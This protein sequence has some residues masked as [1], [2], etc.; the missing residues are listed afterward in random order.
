MKSMADK[1]TYLDLRDRRESF[2][3]LGRETFDVLI[4]GAGITG[5]G[6]A[7]DAARRGLRVAL[8]DA[9]D[10]GAGTSSRSSKLIHGGLRYL[11]QKDVLVVRE[12]AVERR[13]V[14]AIAPHLA[15]LIPI[16]I[17]FE[18]RGL[19]AQLRAALWSYE[20]LGR[21]AQEER[22]EV[23]DVER[24]KA[25]E[26]VLSANGLLGAVV[27]PE[28]L[29]DDFRLTLANARSAAGHGARIVT[30]ASVEEMIFE[31]GRVAGALVRGV[32]PG[33]DETVEV[34]ARAVVNAAG[35][36]VDAVR[37]LEDRS[38]PS[39][40]QLTK[41]IHLVIPR[42]RLPINRTIAMMTSDGRSIIAVPRGGSVYLGSTD[43]FH[44]GPE[45]WP[46]ITGEEVE[47]L[48]KPL[49]RMCA[50]TPIRWEDLAGAWSGLRPMLAAEGKKPSEISRRHEIFDGP[51]G[52]ITVAG[53]KLT[54]FRSM[55][56]RVVDRVEKLL[57]R[58]PSPS[59]T[60]EDPLP[61]GGLFGTLEELKADLRGLGM[62]PDESERAA[63][64]YG[65]EALEVFEQEKGL[66]AEVRWA[67]EKEG[68]LTLEDYWFRRSSRARF[69][70]NGRDNLGPT[71]VEMGKLLDWTEEELGRQIKGCREK[72]ASEMS[73]L[74]QT[75]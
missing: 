7:R 10:V 56:E 25:A 26:P 24:L 48:L 12:A 71:A 51:A 31:N 52:M 54:S 44:A 13:T 38:G 69:D 46:E 30:Y 55:A 29:T 41:G 33:E 27:Y 72:S 35:P 22:H 17:P 42:V 1:S 34:R 2:T 28:C 63:L 9:R 8:V 40:L 6:T 64:L 74:E 60:A 68:A 67:V 15:Q 39:R 32:L 43:T 19:M 53:G 21:V 57:G 16:V 61:G 70:E 3:A 20:K 66:I 11:A 47:Y 62:S 49:N 73:F 50:C 59:T 65:A 37:K 45:Y 75:R 36:W 14:R 4:V 58:R 5:C 23:W 18:S